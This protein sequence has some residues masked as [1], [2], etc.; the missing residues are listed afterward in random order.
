[1]KPTEHQHDPADHVVDDH[2][3]AA[4]VHGDS[5]ETVVPH[6]GSAAVDAAREGAVEDVDQALGGHI[7]LR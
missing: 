5:D 4:A 7:P 6:G 2:V 3:D 1:M